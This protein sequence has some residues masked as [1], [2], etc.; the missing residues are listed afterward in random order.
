MPALL[1]LPHRHLNQEAGAAL[2]SVGSGL[3]LWQREGGRAQLPLPGSE[4][5]EVSA[6][7]S[8]S[9]FLVGHCS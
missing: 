6:V 7:N 5:V 8:T 4:K 2:L 9:S 3:Q 1:T